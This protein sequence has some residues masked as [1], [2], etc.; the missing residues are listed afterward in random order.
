MDSENVFSKRIIQ[1]EFIIIIVNI[2]YVK[3]TTLA[4]KLKSKIKTKYN[5]LFKLWD[6]FLPTSTRLV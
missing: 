3:T 6:K 5:F 1:T 4:R 2:S